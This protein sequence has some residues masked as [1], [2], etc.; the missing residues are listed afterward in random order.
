MWNRSS[1]ADFSLSPSKLSSPVSPSLPSRWWTSW[2]PVSDRKC[3]L[4]T[5]KSR[6]VSRSARSRSRK[7]YSERGRRTSRATGCS[8]PTSCTGCR[9][10]CPLYARAPT[11]TARAPRCSGRSSA[12]LPHVVGRS[13]RVGSGRWGRRASLRSP[14]DEGSVGGTLRVNL[15]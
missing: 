8:P 11:E 2:G 14:G 10:W 7:V 9:A 12:C 1:A 5:G 4:P 13:G 6:R 3:I 15:A